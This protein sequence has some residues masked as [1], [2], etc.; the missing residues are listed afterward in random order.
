M[1]KRKQRERLKLSRSEDA[2][3]RLAVSVIADYLNGDL[4]EKDHKHFEA[5]LAGCKD[6]TAFF[7]T[8]QQS[9]R[10]VKA[11]KY[12]ALPP[13]LQTRSLDFVRKKVKP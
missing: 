7:N 13:E 11:L 6:C 12:E 3:C 5:H 8:Y 1:T 9:V 10:A 2:L 4:S